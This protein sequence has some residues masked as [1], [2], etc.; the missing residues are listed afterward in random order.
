MDFAA[1][2]DYALDQAERKAEGQVLDAIEEN[3]PDEADPS[4]W[5]W[6]ALAKMAN[7]RWQLEPPR[8]RSEAGRPRRRGRVAHREGPRGDA[9]GGPQPTGAASWRPTSA[10]RRP[11]AGCSYKFGIALRREEVADLDAGGLQGAGPPAAPKR[12]TTRRK[13]NTR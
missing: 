10:C 11:A 6:E 4:E 7:T 2:A 13:S 3:L 1:A 8:P 12:P 9:Q 5:N